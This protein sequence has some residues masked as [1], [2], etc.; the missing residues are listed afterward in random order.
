MGLKH[1]AAAARKWRSAARQVAR[2][3]PAHLPPLLFLT[4]PQR[5]LDPVAI[6]ENLPPDA[7]VIYRHFGA[8]DRRII[9]RKLSQACKKRGLCFLVA[10]DAQLACNVDADGVHWP[11]AM[12]KRAV[13][14]RGRFAIQTGSAHSVAAIRR[15]YDI[16]LDAAL[17]SAVFPSNSPSASNPIGIARFR[18]WVKDAPLPVYGLGGVSPDNAGSIAD[19]SG[20]AGIDGFLR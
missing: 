10:A 3:F 7:G 16:G 14:W 6:I 13:N 4:D 8:A 2:H 11:E 9:A 18:A 15:A 20:L 1:Q 19:I 5:T 17:V 12:L